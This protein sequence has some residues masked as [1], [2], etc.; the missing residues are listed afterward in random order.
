MLGRLLVLGL[1]VGAACVVIPDP[2]HCANQSGDATCVELDL[3]AYCSACKRGHRGCVS[4]PPPADCRSA[5]GGETS[6]TSAPT[7]AGSDGTASDTGLP[8]CDPECPADAPYCIAAQCTSCTDA[9]GDEF[10]AGLDPA[11]PQCH[12]T[13]G[14]CAACVVDGSPACEPDASFCDDA[15][16]C[17]GCTEHSQCPDSACDL[18]M[19]RCMD[20]APQLWVDNDPCEADPM[21]TKESPYCTLADAL[22]VVGPGDTTAV[23]HIAPGV[24]YAEGL[25]WS[26]C[27]SNRRL[28]ILGTGSLD[29]VLQASPNVVDLRCAN[30]LYVSK[31]RLNTGSMAGVYCQDAAIWIDDSAL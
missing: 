16:A 2:D 15:Y 23:I 12:P 6:A 29:T 10:C 26:D 1:A 17:G 24:P 4:A 5:A 14:S 13:W 7:S 21:G 27:A 25:A 18:E 9:G 20:D 30:A 3:G 19:G 31:V 22:A 11:Q 8:S 28:A